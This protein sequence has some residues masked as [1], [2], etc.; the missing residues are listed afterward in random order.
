VRLGLPLLR[1]QRGGV[2]G[3]EQIAHR[4][5]Q[6]L[7]V[8][9]PLGAVLA[10][11]PWNF[12]FWQVFRFAAPALMAGNVGLLKHSSNVCGCALSIEEILHGAGV[13]KV[14]FRALLIGSKRVSRLIGAPE[15]KAV[16]LT[17]S[18]PAGR[19]SRQG[20]RGAQE[21]GAGARRQ[22]SLRG[23][24]GCRPRGRGRGLRD[25][26][27][28]QQRPELRRREAVHRRRAVR[29]R[30]RSCSSRR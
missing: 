4:R 11:M 3:P 16:T 25:V 15:V 8:F 30:S 10:V 7:R 17:G 5:Q 13:P 18:T 9:Q 27:A 12:P 29:R 1:R 21:D 28:D 2:P 6:E 23:A 14:R 20:R 24:R 26:A 22:R 19:R